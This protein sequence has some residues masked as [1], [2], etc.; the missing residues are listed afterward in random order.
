MLDFRPDLSS[1]DVTWERM[2]AVAFTP[3]DARARNQLI[4][5]AYGDIADAMA[6]VLGCED[7]SFCA[8][9]QW[10]SAAIAGY[11]SV[12]V[13]FIRRMVSRPFAFG[14]RHIFSEVARA[15]VAFLDTVGAAHQD[16]ADPTEMELA[17]GRCEDLL[18]RVAPWPPG[19]PATARDAQNP[20]EVAAMVIDPTRRTDNDFMVEGLRSYFQAIGCTDRDQKSR[21]ILRG[22]V[23]IAA[24]EQRQLD[25]SI[26][27]GFRTWVRQI[28]TAWRLLETKYE[29]HNHRPGA[30]RLALEG[31]W[32]AFATQ[33]LVT[34]EVPWGSVRVGQRVSRDAHSID[35]PSDL[36]DVLGLRTALDGQGCR[37][38][39][40][41]DQRMAWIIPMMAAV[42]RNP[43]WFDGDGRVARPQLSGDIDRYLE[44]R[45]R[46][47]DALPD[48][49]PAPDS[50]PIDSETLEL[51]RS[52]PTNQAQPLFADFPLSAVWKVGR[53]LAADDVTASFF[54]L[55]GDVIE[56]RDAI[57]QPGGLLDA[58][59]VATARQVFCDNDTSMFMGLLFGSLPD[60]YSAARGVR[61]LGSVSDF[62]VDPFRRAGETARFLLDVLTPPQGA[63]PGSFEVGG[64]ALDST[65]GVRGMHA[66]VT[67]QLIA[68]GWDTS[69]MGVPVN[70]EDLLGTMLTFVVGPFSMFERLGVSFTDGQRDAYTRFWCGIA[71][72]LGLPYEVVTVELDG[73]RRA[74]TYAEAC[75]LMAMIRHRNH[76]VSL[77]GVRLTEALLDGI[78]EG[79]PRWMDWLPLGMVEA[80]GAPEVN[81]YLLLGEGRGR[82]RAAAMTWAMRSGFASRLLQPAMRRALEAAGDYW[83]KPFFAIGAGLPFRRTVEQG[84]RPVIERQVGVGVVNTDL[85]PTGC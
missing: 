43:A 3:M 82:R 45:D 20:S 30:R 65:I 40:D 54:A 57:T 81:R 18:R 9:G 36:A 6:T 10:A 76:A 38:W 29:W 56:R 83:L 24:H 52:R 71:H 37:C 13:P 25:S 75:A 69:T 63:A 66:V 78:G 74:Y 22:N 31:R 8:I 84:G 7:A 4:T 5:V 67:E 49:P 62:A 64:V 17:W 41:W 47:V 23:L 73:R 2:E 19:T 11:L 44:A 16:G 1:R 26:S 32:I 28:T 39:A 21:L 79:F 68:G 80:V 61:V 12:P 46:R 59:T 35:L 42:Q 60:A 70:Q 51:L 27:L 50:S 72:L 48:P 33:R 53:G 77:D 58:D 34:F 15:Q 55:M 85:W 14:N